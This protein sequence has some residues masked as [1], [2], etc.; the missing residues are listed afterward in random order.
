MSDEDILAAAKARRHVRVLKVDG[1]L[2]A[3]ALKLPANATVVDFCPHVYFSENA[4]ALKVH[5]PDFSPAVDGQQLP[6][7]DAIYHKEPG[8]PVEFVG[9]K[10]EGIGLPPEADAPAVAPA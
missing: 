8:K 10:G 4:W 2:L 1:E 6:P 7:V 5:C 3:A 9:W